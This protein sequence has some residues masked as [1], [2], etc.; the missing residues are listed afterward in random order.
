MRR[1][2]DQLREFIKNKAEDYQNTYREVSQSSYY[3]EPEFKA[4]T[5]LLLPLLLEALDALE[6]YADGNNWEHLNKE[7]TDYI[8][9]SDDQGIGDFQITSVTDDEYVGGRRSREALKSI[10][11]KI[12]AKCR[13]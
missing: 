11:E 3:V 2:E 9:I 4:G 13:K 12:G 10:S 8:A 7:S 6:F 5:E 1:T